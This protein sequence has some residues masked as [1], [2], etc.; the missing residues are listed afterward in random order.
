MVMGLL[1]RLAQPGPVALP[2]EE[3]RLALAALL[4]RAARADGSYERAEAARI[5]RVLMGRFGLDAAAAAALRAEAEAVEAE[6]PDTVRFTRVLKDAVPLE[7][8]IGLIEA[9]W[10]VVLADGTRDPGE[11]RL[12]RLVAPLLGI[13]DRDSGLAR[14]RMERKGI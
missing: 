4:V 11:D 10:A 7:D 5:D 6:A 12:M 14:Q 2:A 3:A 9:M 1:R 13:S 8:R